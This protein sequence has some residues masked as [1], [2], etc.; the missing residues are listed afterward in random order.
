[1][2]KSFNGAANVAVIGASGGIGKA[3][4]KL[5]N[6]DPGVAQIHA[7]SRSAARNPTHKPD[8]VA[9]IHA[10]YDLCIVIVCP[11]FENMASV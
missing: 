7:F 8:E 1:M 4:V 6:D 2:M 5:L 10:K 9:A 11:R 3:V